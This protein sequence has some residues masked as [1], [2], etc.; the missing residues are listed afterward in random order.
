MIRGMIRRALLAVALLAFAAPPATAERKFVATAP[1]LVRAIEQARPGDI[2]TLAPGT[3][4]LGRVPV[5]RPG[6][7]AFP[8]VVT[9][10]APGLA[11]IES[12]AV[13]T[14]WV[15]A[16]YW[17]FENLEMVGVCGNHSYC[18]HAFHLVGGGSRVTIRNNV[19]RDYNAQIKANGTGGPV[20]LF[21]DEV[22]IE[23]N[24]IYNGTPRRTDNPVALI[25]AV[26]G[27]RWLVRGN[28]IA[29]FAKDGGDGVSYAAFLKGNSRDGVFER[30]LV[31]CEWRHKG[32]IRVGLSFGGGGT[33]ADACEGRDCS[34]EHRDGSMRN[35]VIAFCPQDVGIYLN[36]AAG[37][38]LYNNLLYETAGI[39]VRFPTSEADIR[40]NVI[41]G[42]IRERD[43]GRARVGLNR[44]AGS[45]LA[46]WLP[47]GGR[48]LKGKIEGARKKY[49][50]WVTVDP[51]VADALAA[52]FGASCFGRC[53][54]EFRD[55]FVAPELLDFRLRPGQQLID[56]GEAL[57][58][59]TDDFCG[60]PRTTPPHDL[61]PI[62]YGDAD[63]DVRARI[64]EPPPK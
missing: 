7:P 25:D 64:P 32:G 46:P 48:W 11:R 49:P 37:T 40:N 28:F 29:D 22:R 54:A 34:A 14:F 39:D 9:A 43:G 44:V 58:A 23:N 15:A 61:G 41:S 10:G 60:R 26:G 55:W 35:N 4:R 47:G 53:P 30:N 12:E 18:E 5:V 27:K 19:L 3:Y 45:W 36:R 56:G 8:I 16:P 59:V 20:R 51:A 42:G 62:E 63:C 17:I 24:A 57:A 2:I 31:L 33:S 1:E 13:E 50:N 38:R 52:W 21:P 6:E